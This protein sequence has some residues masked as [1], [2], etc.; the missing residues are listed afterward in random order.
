MLMRMTR[1][2]LEGVMPRSDLEMAF[3]MAAMALVSYGWTITV[4]E[5]GAEM[6]AIVFSGVM[7]P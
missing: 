6:P 2:S 4:R 1:P 7:A 5:S 3:S